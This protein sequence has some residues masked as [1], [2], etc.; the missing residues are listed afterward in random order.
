M[1]EENNHVK[2]VT[3]LLNTARTK[4]IPLRECEFLIERLKSDMD[5]K[6]YN[7]LYAD[8]KK[9]QDIGSNISARIQ[10]LVYAYYIAGLL[11]EIKLLEK[12]NVDTKNLPL[13]IT[14]IINLYKDC[15]YEVLGNEI[16]RVHSNLT[17]LKARKFMDIKMELSRYRAELLTV[18]IN[19]GLDAV[20]EK[21]FSRANELIEAQDIARTL[22]IKQEIVNYIQQRKENVNTLLITRL[23]NVEEKVNALWNNE[24]PGKIV[25]L[26]TEAK[27][28]LTKNQI[29]D[30]Q[31]LLSEIEQLIPTKPRDNRCPKCVSG[32]MLFEDNGTAR[33][34]SCSYMYKWIAI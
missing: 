12:L 16:E 33:C 24:L 3:E 32:K 14:N 5:L 27:T 19:A 23:K 31:K 15:N 25:E 9:L 26:L 30:I 7:Q 29:T 22:Q 4:S 2:E 11:T 8:C 28:K 10:S 17:E 34:L 13:E 1:P 6:L 18:S 21:L 20:S